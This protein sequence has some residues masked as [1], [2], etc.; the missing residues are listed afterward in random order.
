MSRDLLREIGELLADAR[1][2]AVSASD[3]AWFD[4]KAD[5]FDALA[6]DATAAGDLDRAARV[7]TAAEDARARARALRRGS[8][9]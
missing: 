9:R 1:S 7:M 8:A 3:P 4:R 2:G 6:V 5:L